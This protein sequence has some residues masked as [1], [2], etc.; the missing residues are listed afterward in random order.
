MS[1]KPTSK[2][3][4]LQKALDQATG[5]L[6]GDV[7]KG[8]RVRLTWPDGYSLTQAIYSADRLR[9]AELNERGTSRHG[10]PIYV[11]TLYDRAAHG[12]DYR[13]YERC[14]HYSAKNQLAYALEFLQRRGAFAPPVQSTSV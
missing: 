14:N 6:P 4:L 8:Y 5:C 11:L 12:E 9:K 1:T 10:K 2:R 3:P 13:E 7:Q